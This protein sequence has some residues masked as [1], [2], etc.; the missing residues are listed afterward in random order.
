VASGFFGTIRSIFTSRRKPSE[1]VLEKYLFVLSGST[2][3]YELTSGKNSPLNICE[4]IH[5]QDLDAEQVSKLV[6]NLERT[7]I[8]VPAEAAAYIHRQTSGHPYLTQR[9]CS[10]LEVRESPEASIAAIDEAVT[11]VLRGDDNLDHMA[12]QLTAEPEMRDLAH[13]I[14]VGTRPLAFSRVDQAVSRLEMIGAIGDSDPCAIRN[15]I[16]QRALERY[17]GLAPQTRSFR[18]HWRRH[19]FTALVA[20]LFLL[21]LPNLILYT[22]EVLLAERFVNQPIALP[23]LNVTGYV[24][25]DALLG[26]GEKEEI[27]V[28]L[29]RTNPADLSPLRVEIKPH[30]QDVASADGNYALIYRQ[31]HESQRFQVLLRK[32]ARLQDFIFPLATKRARRVD[33]FVLPEGKPRPA[34]IAPTYTLTMR[35]DYFSTFV[36]SALV[37]FLS[38]LAGIGSLLGRLDMVGDWLAPLTRFFRPDKGKN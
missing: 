32:S 1:Q 30:E 11:E 10:I 5:L 26:L 36:G 2:E 13:R 28:E 8:R 7:G 22:T 6:A 15:L 27:E 29:V 38:I 3:L 19:L 24:R 16:Y 9:L 14:L 34:E 33:V 25:Y 20:L 35:V 18:S 4:T 23:A 12:R 37:W 21:T 31:A 17:F